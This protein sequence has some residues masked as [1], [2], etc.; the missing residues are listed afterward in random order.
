MA[1]PGCTQ[2]SPTTQSPVTMHEQPSEFPQVVPAWHTLQVV[3]GKLPVQVVHGMLLVATRHP[4][5]SNP[6]VTCVVPLQVVPAPEQPVG[7]GGHAQSALGTEPEQGL[8]A[9]QLEVVAE[10]QPL[11]LTVQVAT[12]LPPRQTLPAPGQSDGAAGQ[13]QVA[14]GKPPVHVL[15]EGHPALAVVPRQPLES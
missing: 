4:F 12:V 7:A 3:F 15:P 14:F 1:P 13:L 5:P 6:Q 11:P 8:P 9:G 10:M 2:V